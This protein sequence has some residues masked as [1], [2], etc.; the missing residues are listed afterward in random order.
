MK[1]KDQ[2]PV[3]DKPKAPPE[4]TQ[5]E[6]QAQ[7]RAVAQNSG[8]LAMADQLAELRDQSLRGLDTN[9][10]LSNERVTAQA[11][12]GA[13]GG[14]TAAFAESATRGSGGIGAV[15]TGDERRT[16][17]GAGL[18]ER[19]TTVV[20]APKGI[21]PDKTKPGMNGDK[22]LAGR[23]MNEI[24][25]VFDRNKGALL[26]II[27][28]GLRDNPDLRGTINIDFTINP[29]GSISGLRIASGS[30]GD[31]DIDRKLLQ[32]IQMFNF[33]AKSVPAFEVK[34]YQLRLL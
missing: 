26:A 9:R 3:Q 8:V 11:G 31:A 33:G 17:S 27:N 21:G 32:R 28:R 19:R 4:P 6:R 24:Q 16:Q 7:A 23:S 2:K 20:E 22:L 10:P 1:A 12:T 30:V 13:T 14:S 25:E 18:G 29:D 5:A 34:N 15:G